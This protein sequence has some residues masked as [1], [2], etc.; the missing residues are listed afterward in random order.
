MIMT[1]TDLGIH[2]KKSKKY[3]NFSTNFP[4]KLIKP[5][6]KFGKKKI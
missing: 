6:K 2:L 1:L 4:V 5:A 3:I